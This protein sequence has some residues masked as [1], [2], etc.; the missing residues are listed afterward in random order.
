MDI[1]KI[2]DALEEYEEDS[3]IGFSDIMEKIIYLLLG[4]KLFSTEETEVI[5]EIVNFCD[6]IELALKAQME[7]KNYIRLL[8]RVKEIEKE[9]EKEE[10]EAQIRRERFLYG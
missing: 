8:N 9:E 3:S 1:K 4:R 5:D 2:Y 7:D 10:E 6:L